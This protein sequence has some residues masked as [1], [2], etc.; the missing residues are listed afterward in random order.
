MRQAFVPAS[1]RDEG[2]VTS[3]KRRRAVAAGDG[4]AISAL[5]ESIVQPGQRGRRGAVAE[6]HLI[7]TSD[8]SCV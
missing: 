8:I 5:Y 1:G 3:K 4:E 7:K 6:S 2:G